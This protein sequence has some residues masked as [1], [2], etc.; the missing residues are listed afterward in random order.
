MNFITLFQII[1]KGFK[2]KL[3]FVQTAFINKRICREK[4]CPEC[5][6]LTVE[7][8]KLRIARK[9]KSPNLHPFCFSSVSEKK[10]KKKEKKKRRRTKRLGFIDN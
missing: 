9:R 8:I 7:H 10:E 2:F 1:H 3:T 6:S 5:V 4:N